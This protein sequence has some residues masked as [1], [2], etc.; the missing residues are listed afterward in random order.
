M[1]KLI[2]VPRTFGRDCRHFFHI[3]TNLSRAFCVL[4][5]SLN[6]HN[7]FDNFGL[8]NGNSCEYISLSNVFNRGT[9]HS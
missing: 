9:K 3:F 6:P 7:R 2:G 4:Y 1:H 8:M 5:P